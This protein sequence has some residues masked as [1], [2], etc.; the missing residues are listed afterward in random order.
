M[1]KPELS[2][3]IPAYNVEQ[4]IKRCIKSVMRQQGLDKCEII[5][6]DDCSTDATPTILDS[7]ANAHKDLI[8]V[9]H[10]PKNSG[11]SVARNVGIEASKGKYVTFGDADDAVGLDVNKFDK[12]FSDKPSTIGELNTYTQ[13]C[14]IASPTQTDYDDK[15]FVNMLSAADQGHYKAD[16][17]LGGHIAIYRNAQCMTRRTYSKETVRGQ[18][19]KDILLIEAAERENANFALYSRKLLDTHNLRFMANMNLDEDILF[20]ML[21]VLYADNVATAP[22]VTYFYDHHCGTLSNMYDEKKHKIAQIQKYSV[23]ANEIAKMPQYMIPKV[24]G[25]WA[26]FYIRYADIRRTECLSL[27]CPK[28]NCADCPVAKTVLARSEQ[29]IEKY[30]PK[31]R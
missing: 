11:V 16:V 7:F 15:Y 17:V 12:Y 9:F 10:L 3:I 25:Y 18:D 19:S 13:L 31:H 21:A 22:D 20:C 5:I 30:F 2:I 23:L 24:F 26:P 8:K 29:S 14:G 28:E 1:K 27:Q 6:V 4:R